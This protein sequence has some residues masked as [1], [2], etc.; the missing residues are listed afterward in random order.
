[1]S[2]HLTSSSV[3]EEEAEEAAEEEARATAEVILVYPW[4]S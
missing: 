2:A 1:M 4:L 3:L